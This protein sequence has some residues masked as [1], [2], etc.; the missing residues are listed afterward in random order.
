MIKRPEIHTDMS[1]QESLDRE[2]S[3]FSSAE[4]LRD[5]QPRRE[6][7]EPLTPK[8]WEFVGATGIIIASPPGSGGSTVSEI[9]PARLGI[10]ENR[11]WYIG[12]LRREA[13]KREA[14]GI[15]IGDERLTVEK[16]LT[17]DGITR[18][19]LA[20]ATFEEPVMVEAQLGGYVGKD[21]NSYRI[22][23]NAE[24]MTRA[25]RVK[26]REDRKVDEEMKD[27]LL[28]PENYE[29]KEEPRKFSLE[30]WRE[31]NKA[32][33]KRNLAS[34]K[35]TYRQ[36]RGKNPFDKD[37]NFSGKKVYDLS[38]D[39][40]NLNPEEIVDAIIFHMQTDGV[41]RKKKRETFAPYTQN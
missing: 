20:D 7:Q 30:E 1:Q 5:F 37:L 27:R 34:W 32:R 2:G 35:K 16:E 39:S 21:T 4:F 31:I 23:I 9:L 10:P 25:A 15:P 19:V 17:T 12:K 14:N 13:L 26:E 36:L 28:H 24:E 18:S 40:T 8:E 22:L 41:I 3:S 29:G 33:T 6:T 38:I 11:S